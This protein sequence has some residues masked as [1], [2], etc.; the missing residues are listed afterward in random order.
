ML[1]MKNGEFTVGYYSMVDFC[2][3]LE[4]CNPKNDYVYLSHEDAVLNIFSQT[5]IASVFLSYGTSGGKSFSFGVESSKFLS[6]WKK[7]YP[8][9]KI[10]FKA[11]KEQLTVSED[12]ISIKFPTVQ[13]VKSYK[14]PEFSVLDSQE[15]AELSVALSVCEGSISANKQA[16]GVLI[17]NTSENIGRVVKIG[18]YSHRMYACRKLSCASTRIVVPDD[19]CSA[20]SA[21]SKWS[22]ASNSFGSVTS[23]LISPSKVGAMLS[24]GVQFYMPTLYDTI[25]ASYIY[26]FRLQDGVPQVAR[27]GRAYLFSQKRLSEVIELISAVVGA[28]ESMLLLE[29]DG[30][31]ASTKLPV[32]RISAKTHNGCEASELLECLDSG[33]TD[34]EPFRI[35]K[36]QSL[37]ALRCY[38]G[39]V[40]MMDR[41]N[42][43]MVVLQ[44]E[45]GRNVTFLLKASA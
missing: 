21:L 38:E 2:R 40:V 26:D 36:G 41:P 13:Y 15:T 34:L 10:V 30:V 16:P 6:L 29:I 44:D 20:V 11:S 19:F 18:N 39:S 12:N 23:F 37:L 45:L 25:P 3:T 33:P 5:T 27:E 32:F 9:S 35:N 17:D 8:G 24:S 4:K 28:E 14:L 42:T 1:E 43:G 22:T 31:S 7:L